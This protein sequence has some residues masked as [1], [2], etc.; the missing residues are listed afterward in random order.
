M[1]FVYALICVAAMIFSAYLALDA[2]RHARDLYAA[3]FG[4]GAWIWGRN[5]V[6]VMK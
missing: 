6:G 2:L 3:F 5:F 4:V 1:R